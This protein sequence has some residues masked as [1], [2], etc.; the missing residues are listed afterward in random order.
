MNASIMR[1][2]R[3]LSHSRSNTGLGHLPWIQSVPSSGVEAM[4][5]LCAGFI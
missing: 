3:A 2:A 1:I 4:K 5:K